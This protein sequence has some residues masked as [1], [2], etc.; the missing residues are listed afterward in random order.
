MWAA[1][2]FDFFLQDRPHRS[3]LRVIARELQAR[4]HLEYLP[5]AAQREAV[6]VQAARHAQWVRPDD[7]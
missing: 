1:R 3:R 6:T 5:K 2:S 4:E 7:Q